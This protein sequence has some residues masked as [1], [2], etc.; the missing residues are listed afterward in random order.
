MIFDEDLNYKITVE[1]LFAKYKSNK[2]LNGVSFDILQGELICLCGPNGCGKS[3]LLSV[4]SGV[5]RQDGGSFLCDGKDLFQ[6]SAL[7]TRLV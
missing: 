2:I 5:L 6:D 3:T 4:L 7:R 1:N